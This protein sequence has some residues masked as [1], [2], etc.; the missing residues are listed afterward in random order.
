MPVGS[1][2][3]AAPGIPNNPLTP[4]S[5]N[6]TYKR[7]NFYDG[8]YSG[9]RGLFHLLRSPVESLALERGAAQ[10]YML[11]QLLRQHRSRLLNCYATHGV[12]TKESEVLALCADTLCCSA[13]IH[14][15]LVAQLD[16]SNSGRSDV[17]VPMATGML[18]F[19]HAA[20]GLDGLCALHFYRDALLAL[21]RHPGEVFR[22][23]NEDIFNA[24]ATIF[25]IQALSDSAHEG[26]RCDLH[27]VM[28]M[29]LE[30]FAQMRGQSMGPEET[31]R[32]RQELERLGQCRPGVGLTRGLASVA[33]SNA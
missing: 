3:E 1:Q 31:R 27:A 28:R 32:M 10:E 22:A 6:Y 13:L 2:G 9:L 24:L 7:P 17:G 25:S 5:M 20:L 14:L 30:E 19:H 21:S 26:L 15:G 16:T 12:Q 11:I 18:W 29:L 8:P 4:M 23:A 33:S